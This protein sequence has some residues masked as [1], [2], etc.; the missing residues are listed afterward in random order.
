MKLQAGRKANAKESTTTALYLL[1]L[2]DLVLI[3]RVYLHIHAPGPDL[4]HL[5]IIECLE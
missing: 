2:V 4:L 3:L 1:Q 5:H